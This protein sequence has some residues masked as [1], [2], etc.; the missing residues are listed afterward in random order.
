[1]NPV[2]ATPP[3]GIAAGGLRATTTTLARRVTLVQSALREMATDNKA[4]RR[5]LARVRAENRTLRAKLDE[6]RSMNGAPPDDT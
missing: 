1:V 4:L 3:E 6:L 5:E 2:M